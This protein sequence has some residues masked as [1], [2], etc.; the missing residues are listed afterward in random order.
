MRTKR[1]GLRGGIKARDDLQNER[2]D[3]PER[4][5]QLRACAAATHTNMFQSTPTFQD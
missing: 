3:F 5:L 1:L 4:T 2:A